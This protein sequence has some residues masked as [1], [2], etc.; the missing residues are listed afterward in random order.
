MQNNLLLLKPQGFDC[1]C[2]NSQQLRGF[3]HMQNTSA[4]VGFK[5]DHI[6]VSFSVSF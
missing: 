2:F 6:L 3:S 1:C 5:L 4:E